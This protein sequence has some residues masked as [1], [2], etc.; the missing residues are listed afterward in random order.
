MVTILVQRFCQMIFIMFG[1]SV[2]VFLIF[3]ATPGADPASRIAGRNAAPE[4]IAA[5]RHDFGL[6]RAL[7]VQYVVMMKK[8]FVTR[9]LVSFTNRGMNVVP[10]ILQA[11]P[12]TL[13]LVFGA[14]I[15]WV[16]GSL[17]FGVVAAALRGSFIDKSLMTF[18]LVGMAVPV[19]WL[20]EVTNLL[21]QSR[22]HDTIF[23]SW[24]PAL[25]YVAFTENPLSWFKVLLLPWLTLSVGYIGIYGR[26]LRANII[27]IYQED[28]IRTARA[29]GISEMRVLLRHA[30]RMSLVPFVTMFG[31][32]FGV[33]VGGGAL[34]TEVIFGLNG[35]G[36]L[37]YDSL[38]SLDLPVIMASVMYAS[39]F[40][41]VANAAVDL[42][43]VMLDPR[44]GRH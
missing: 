11:T 44:I 37:T 9:D 30:L 32:D 34:V 20:A 22:F 43:Y 38:Q 31:L 28:F 16:L 25:G 41:V 13:S 36:K 23:F 33:L 15:F 21:S 40:V 3:F 1:I 10:A 35:V 14:A 2:L 39:F 5:V 8:L 24:V 26:V 7:P 27:E 42:T 4:T 6:D 17:L 18:S 29:K 19:F 12:V